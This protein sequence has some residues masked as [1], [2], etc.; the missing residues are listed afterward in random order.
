L[1]SGSGS[2]RT[3]LWRV[4]WHDFTAHP[5][6]GSG[7]GS[8]E[9][10]WYRYR[11]YTLDASHAHELYLE[12][13]AEL[14]PLGLALLLVSLGA[15]LVAAWR[16]RRHP[17]A[18][19]ATAA[20]VAF[21]AHVAADRDWQVAAVGLVAIASAATLLVLARETPS[22]PAGTAGR[23]CAA[24]AG[25]V[26]ALFA[27]WGLW[28]AYPL[29]QARDAAAAQDWTRVESEAARAVRRRPGS[30]S[31][32]WQLLGEAQSARGAPAA[33][34]ASLRV[35]VARDPDSWAAW[36]DLADV[37][38][39]DARRAAARHA[40]V[41]NPRDPGVQSLARTLGLVD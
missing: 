9:A 21:L 13:L 22:A 4:A 23:T 14:G 36:R 2:Y 35:A 41:L 24:L 1:L 34:R 15:P 40:L 37:S 33:A 10:R 20:Y 39:G 32:A 3:L 5:A 8:F 31:L 26:L 25:G 17:L 6:V 27:L 11:S 28:G 7:A 19:G 30:S 16:A 38:S 12:T 18:A 29:G